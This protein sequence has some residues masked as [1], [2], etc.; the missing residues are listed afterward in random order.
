MK[1]S[2]W[3]IGFFILLISLHYLLL[4]FLPSMEPSSNFVLIY[5]CLIAVN[6]IGITLFYFQD[7]LSLMPFA[8]MFLVFTTIQLL[9]CM[10]F[11]L[12]IKMLYPEN[13][14]I[15]LIH[16]VVAF[17]IVLA[18]QSIYLIKK[19]SKSSTSLE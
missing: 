8:G 2:L 19:Q 5:A 3:S 6:A 16:F 12:A 1:D 17:F 10:S 13:A 4:P 11:A 18:V 15:T 9:A 7:K 14:K